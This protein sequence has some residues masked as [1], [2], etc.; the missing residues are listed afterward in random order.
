MTLKNDWKATP[1][2]IFIHE[3]KFN[4]KSFDGNLK[5]AMN[6][7]CH[8]DYYDAIR[9]YHMHIHTHGKYF[10]FHVIL[11]HIHETFALKLPS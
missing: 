10:S 5:A 9:Y 8:F 7:E 4:R 6:P 3:I 2:Q 1:K 11:S